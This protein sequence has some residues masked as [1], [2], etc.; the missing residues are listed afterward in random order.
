[1][2]L[3]C[4]SGAAHQVQQR[5]VGTVLHDHE[6]QVVLVAIVVD[7]DDVGVVE[8]GSRQRFLLEARPEAGV[9]SIDAM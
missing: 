4:S 9:G 3:L 1:M 5:A 7:V 6:R 8:T 2:G